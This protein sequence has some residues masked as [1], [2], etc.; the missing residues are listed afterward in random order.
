MKP[1]SVRIGPVV[2]EDAGAITPPI[3]FTPFSQAFFAI[4]MS[5]VFLASISNQAS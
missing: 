3:N 1:Y 2:S 5:R 4:V